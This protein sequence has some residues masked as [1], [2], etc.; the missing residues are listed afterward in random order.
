MQK[1][2][3]NPYGMVSRNNNKKNV[4]DG[5]HRIGQSIEIEHTV[6]KNDVSV[7]EMRD[8]RI[9]R[10]ANKEDAMIRCTARPPSIRNP[11]LSFVAPMRTNLMDVFW[12]MEDVLVRLLSIFNTFS[13]ATISHTALHNTCKRPLE[14][15]LADAFRSA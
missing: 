9:S 13:S 5:H 1:I 15:W 12:T 3:P 10:S 7:S 8:C 14:P 6:S 2:L 11:P 4:S